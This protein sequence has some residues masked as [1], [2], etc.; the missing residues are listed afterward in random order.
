MIY[1]ANDQTLI[2]KIKALAPEDPVD[3]HYEEDNGRRTP[4]QIWFDIRQSN[5]SFFFLSNDQ[6]FNGGGQTKEGYQY[7]WQIQFGE[8]KKFDCYFED[9]LKMGESAKFLIVET[10]TK[11][12]G[13]FETKEAAAEW[14]TKNPRVE[15]RVLEIANEI[16]PEITIKLRMSIGNMGHAMWRWH[17]FT[18]RQTPP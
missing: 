3:C 16:K 18:S 6:R 13:S 12:V 11:R 9:M 1:R 15:C 2:E 17:V 10:R 14:I 4:G 8:N 7:S 5:G